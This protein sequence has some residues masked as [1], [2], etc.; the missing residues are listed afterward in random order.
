MKL[1]QAHVTK[2]KSIE[3]STLVD[4][5]KNVTVMVGVNEAGKSAFLESLYKAESVLDDDEYNQVFDYPRKDWLTYKRRDDQEESSVVARLSYELEPEE[6]KAIEAELGDDVLSGKVYKVIHHIDNTSNVIVPVTEGAFVARLIAAAT[7]S[8]SVRAKFASAGT[9]DEIITILD[10]ETL[11]GDDETFL[12]E[13][14]TKYKVSNKS[15]ADTRLGNYIYRNYIVGKV[16][17]FL[18]FSDYYI[19]PGKINISQLQA[20]KENGTTDNGLRTA[21]GLLEMANIS[22][23]E[24]QNPDSYEEIRAEL[25]AVSLDISKKVFK[26]WTQNSQLKVVFDVKADPNEEAPFNTGVNLYIRV[27]NI[28]HGVTVPFDQ[29]SKGFVWFFS[30]IVWFNSVKSRIGTEKDLILLLDEPGLSLHGLAQADFLHYI[31]DLSE[32][33]QILYTTHSPFMID[34]EKLQQ[35]RTVEDVSGKGTVVAGNLSSTDKRT[36]FPL[37]AG[38]GYSLAQN[39][40]IGAKNVLVEGPA[41]LIFWKYFSALL[42]Q[43]GR[44]GLHDG[45]VIVPTG[46]LDKI[47]TFVSLLAGNNLDMAVVH[48]Y[49]GTSDRRLASLVQ[50]KIIKDKQVMN[51]AQFRDADNLKASDVED[52][53]SEDMY[54]EVFNAAYATPLKGVKIEAK[55]LP[56]GD[57]MTQRIEKYLTAKKIS[58]RPSGGYNHYLVASHLASNPVP[59]KSVDSETLNRFEAMF[60]ELN[61]L[62]G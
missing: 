9:I 50:N 7:V 55:D 31:A 56:K 60:K 36:L 27:E 43:D 24:L 20:A 38:L 8:E 33:H 28:D 25:E 4:V 26:Y 51:Y 49:E 44:V 22:T 13:L 52:M 1:T 58:L 10:S 41:D 16:P 35:V 23:D 61:S 11:T 45:I 21:L 42:E 12:S 62:L 3:D 2:Y 59:K 29:R 14:K 47:A 15:W 37:Q 39:L 57:R 17:K 5:D 48:D 18:Y 53:L 34:S 19:L 54:L 46:G 6:V 30:F 32:E 40:F